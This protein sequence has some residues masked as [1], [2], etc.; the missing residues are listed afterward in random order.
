VCRFIVTSIAVKTLFELLNDTCVGIGSGN[1]M[2]FISDDQE[3]TYLTL[4]FSMKISLVI[5][6][7]RSVNSPLRCACA[8]HEKVCAGLKLLVCLT[9]QRTA[10]C[11]K[12]HPH[13]D[14]T[15][16]CTY[17]YRFQK[18]F[19]KEAVG[20]IIISICVVFL[21]THSPCLCVQTTNY[22]IVRL[23]CQ[24]YVSIQGLF[25]MPVCPVI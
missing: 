24:D 6:A 20:P 13:A 10:S 22:E 9:L 23:L 17:W 18:S 11:H 5:A 3:A 2:S 21:C 7:L 14:R 1:K 19:L 4:G 25:I 12:M 15:C 8:Q 16:C